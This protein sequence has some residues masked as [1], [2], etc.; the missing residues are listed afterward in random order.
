MRI[1]Y[2]FFPERFVRRGSSLFYRIAESISRSKPELELELKRANL[3]SGAAGYIAA[4]I[5]SDSILFIFMAAFMLAL[6]FKYKS[7][8]PIPVALLVSFVVSVFIFFQQTTYPKSIIIKKV[9][10]IER[11]LLPALRTMQIQL[12][13]GIPL[14]NII[15]SISNED[16]GGVSEQFKR[17]VKEINA[18]MHQVNALESMAAE[19]P[20][21]YFQRVIWQLVTAM[22]SGS[23]LGSVMNELIQSLSEEQLVEV[24]DYGS[25]LNPLTMFYMLLVVVVPAL[26]VTFFVVL[27]SFLALNEPTLKGLFWGMYGAVFLFQLFFLSMISSK[28]PNML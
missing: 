10:G 23:D 3:K 8:Y 6:L 13:S 19:N 15:V 26:A 20:S 25:K 28:R 9:K 4:S 16:Y 14:Y 27:G 1:P 18:G 5:F 7:P 22:K 11:H 12:S 17:A 24:Q 2:C 21:I